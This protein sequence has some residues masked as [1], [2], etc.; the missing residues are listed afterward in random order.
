MEVAGQDLELK[1]YDVGSF[2]S[3]LAAFIELL[4][5]I[6]SQV[7]ALG[8]PYWRWNAYRELV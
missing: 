6:S 3:L 8:P 1:S 4:M 2:G 7:Y 5:A